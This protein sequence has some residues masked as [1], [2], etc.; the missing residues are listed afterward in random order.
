MILTPGNE[1]KYKLVTEMD[2]KI[3]DDNISYMTKTAT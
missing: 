3:N 1:A 2:K